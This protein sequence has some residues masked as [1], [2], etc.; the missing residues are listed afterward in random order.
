MQA[1][2]EKESLLF[3]LPCCLSD[4][5]PDKE[6]LKN[7][8]RKMDERVILYNKISAKINVRCV[9]IKEDNK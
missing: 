6:H 2:R 8:E 9:N 1:K 7:E 5:G 3:C 4:C